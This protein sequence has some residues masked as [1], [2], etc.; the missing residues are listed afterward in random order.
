M[1]VI[2]IILFYE[3]QIAYNLRSSHLAETSRVP[4][5]ETVGAW[6]W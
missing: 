2:T 5:F 4:D 6:W 3:L 1:S